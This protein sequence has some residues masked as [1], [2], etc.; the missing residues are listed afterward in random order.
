MSKFRIK[1]LLPLDVALEAPF[2]V[3][4]VKRA[5]QAHGITGATLRRL[6][7]AERITGAPFTEK[8]RKF[9]AESP[10]G[11]VSEIGGSALAL[12][13]S[14]PA[15]IAGSAYGGPWAGGVAA[16]TLAY[17]TGSWLGRKALAPIDKALFQKQL[18]RTAQIKSELERYRGA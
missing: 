9:K 16:G 6:E 5:R 7:R 15:A 13:A 14:I 4:G 2:A 18:K 8:A 17:G 10:A 11:P 3:S 1:A 12:G